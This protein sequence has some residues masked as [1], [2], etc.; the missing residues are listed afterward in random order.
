MITLKE[1]LGKTDYNSIPK[2]HQANI[3]ILLERINKVRSALDK[4]MIITSGYRSKD[5]HIRIYK[6]LATKR[7]EIFDEKKI[8]WGSSH[9][10][11]AAVDIS[12]NNGSLYEWCQKN[13]ALLVEIGLWMEEK[14]D[15]KRVHFQ[16][17]APAS[18][19]RFFKP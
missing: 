2:D 6:E 16:I 4:P 11:G 7:K 18:G 5:D 3:M 1:L 8:P 14:D 9:L 10:K 13:E 15:Q 17:F 19:K 12:D